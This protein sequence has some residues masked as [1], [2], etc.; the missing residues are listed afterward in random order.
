MT[1]II[2]NIIIFIALQYCRRD[3]ILYG[4][5]DGMWHSHQDGYR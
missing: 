3:Y 2:I 5:Y 4:V 1:M